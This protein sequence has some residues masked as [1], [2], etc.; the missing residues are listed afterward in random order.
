[1]SDEPLTGR[2][3]DEP[4]RTPPTPAPEPP[5]PASGYSTPAPERPTPAPEHRTSA[6]ERPA[7]TPG[8][9]TPA[10]EHPAPDPHLSTALHRL[11]ESSR[12]PAPGTG[13]QVRR[14]AQA[15]KRRRAV[16]AGGVA[17]GVGALVFGLV[18]GLGGAD[19]S[20]PAPPAAPP[21]R[22]ASATAPA[23]GVDL[24]ARTLTVR[25]RTLPVSSGT[26][27]HPTKPGRTTVVAKHR[28]KRLSGA[29]AGLGDAYDLTLPWVV[30]LRDS[31]GRTNY[32]VALT[33]DDAAPGARDI[34]HGMLGLRP[35]DAKW[36]YG[37]VAPGSVV[38]IEGA[39]PPTP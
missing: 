15:R 37:Q 29:T 20:G 35:A 2:P 39:A 32:L 34:T 30:E 25:G 5:A 7:P 38:T 16:V 3:A 36:L 18:T 17:A 24:A 12:A 27:S 28:T 19:G 6:P 22:T 31:G 11:A 13:A 14:R 33:Y 1:M 21:S 8:Y 4:G 9:P 10:P 26:A 23:V